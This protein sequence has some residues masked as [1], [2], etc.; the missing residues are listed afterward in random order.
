[1]SESVT[2]RPELWITSLLTNG[3][4]TLLAYPGAFL[5]L[6]VGP[7]RIAGFDWT[8]WLLYVF[9][10]VNMLSLPL[11]LFARRRPGLLTF[12]LCVAGAGVVYCV[13]LGLAIFVFGRW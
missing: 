8:S 4:L 11:L 5:L 13:Y 2:T 1:M 12:T 7:Q 10:W 3:A 9:P 6:A